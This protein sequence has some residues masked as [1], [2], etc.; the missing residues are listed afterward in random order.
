MKGGRNDVLEGRLY[1]SDFVVWDGNP[2]KGKGSVIAAIQDD[3]KV[4]YCCPD[5]KST[6]I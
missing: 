4:G 6:A 5:V 1:H 3:R 2:L